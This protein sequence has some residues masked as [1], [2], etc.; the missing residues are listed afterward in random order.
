MGSA[1]FDDGAVLREG[2][3]LLYERVEVENFARS[4]TVQSVRWGTE[5]K[6]LLK[7]MN[8]E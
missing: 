5:L 8:S 2:V 3:K 1:A 4:R 6:A 7:S